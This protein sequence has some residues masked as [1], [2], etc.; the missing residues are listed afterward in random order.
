MD[1]GIGER[2]A[3]ALAAKDRPALLDVLDPQLDFRGLTPAKFWEASSAETLVD[4]IVLGA[5]FEPDDH[6][7]SLEAVQ[8]GSVVD[9][10]HVSY[11]LRIDNPD[12]AFVVEQQAYYGVEG[13]RINWLRILCSGYR[14]VDA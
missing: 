3:K 9:R 12:G 5:W 11:R 14:R 10:P 4:D 8:T 6:I 7:R 13:D 1:S 2:F